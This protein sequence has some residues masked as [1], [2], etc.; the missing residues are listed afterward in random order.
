M[1]RTTTDFITSKPDWASTLNTM[2]Q[3][4]FGTICK[5]KWLRNLLRNKKAV[6]NNFVTNGFFVCGPPWTVF[7]LW[8]RKLLGIFLFQ[9]WQ[10]KPFYLGKDGGAKAATSAEGG[11]CWPIGPWFLGMGTHRAIYESY[12]RRQQNDQNY[13]TLGL[14]IFIYGF[15][16]ALLTRFL[17]SKMESI[18]ID[19]KATRWHIIV[20]F[21]SS[22]LTWLLKI[23]Y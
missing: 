5:V 4:T 1:S 14:T 2:E 22:I 10:L 13:P 6:D 8:F 7:E 11:S 16:R 23:N 9:N 15:H 17:R 12:C 20:T 21:V 19:T 3:T 18:T